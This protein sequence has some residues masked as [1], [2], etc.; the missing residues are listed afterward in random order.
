[1]NHSI[2]AR[3]LLASS[4]ALATPL[5]ASAAPN[6]P[7]LAFASSA[8][9]AVSDVNAQP[10]GTEN[11]GPGFLSVTFTNTSNVAANEVVFELDANGRY[12]R[13]IHDVGTFA[14]GVAIKHGYYDLSGASDQQVKVVKVKF[15]DGTS[16]SNSEATAPRSRRQ[17]S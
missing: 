6:A 8:P 17:A 2:L 5:A 3:T 15:N 7:A 10:T 16:W 13:L 11:Q 4:M 9:I 1:M 14:P 12:N